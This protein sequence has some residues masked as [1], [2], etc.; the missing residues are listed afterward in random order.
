MYKNCR[1]EDMIKL[2]T[3]IAETPP[4]GLTVAQLKDRIEECKM[5]QDDPEFVTN[6]LTSITEDRKLKETNEIRAREAELALEKIK[7]AQLE[8]EVE[9]EKVK[10]QRINKNELPGLSS[11][12]IS[13][14][15]NLEK[16]IQS[17]RTLTIPI[18]DKSENFNLFFRTLERAFKTKNVP[19]NLKAEI[20]INLLGDKAKNILFYITED[21]IKSYDTVKLLVCREFQPTAQECLNNFRKAKREANKTHT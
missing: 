4:F 11:D 5:F 16:L 6:L 1:K 7:L 21:D 13:D 12:T 18:P 10:S 9:L 14:S 2:L 17:I 3:E 19:D 20:L 8:Q 15:C